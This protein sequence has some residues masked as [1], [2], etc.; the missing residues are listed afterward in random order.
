MSPL[1]DVAQ[2][3]DRTLISVAVALEILRKKHV[4]RFVGVVAMLHL[5]RARH[6]GGRV[7]FLLR[8]FQ[9]WC[10]RAVIAIQS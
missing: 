7:H 2:G 1:C 4:V 9:P 8:C 6:K 10:K 5:L 3:P